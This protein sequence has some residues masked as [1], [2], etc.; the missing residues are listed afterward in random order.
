M[1]S[2]GASGSVSIL[3]RIETL[4]GHHHCS[5]IT[6]HLIVGTAPQTIMSYADPRLSHVVRN[7]ALGILPSG[8]HPPCNMS[9]CPNFCADQSIIKAISPLET[10]PKRYGAPEWGSRPQI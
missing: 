4:G 2:L 1:G 9:H 6:R 8:C 5:I 10:S 3:V 7:A